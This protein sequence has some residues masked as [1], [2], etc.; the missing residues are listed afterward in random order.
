MSGV[1]LGVTFFGHKDPTGRAAIVAES[2]QSSATKL[3]EPPL[4]NKVLSFSLSYSC[5]PSTILAASPLC[6][7]LLSWL[8][9]ACNLR[10]L[11]W[12]RWVALP[13]H[14][15]N[16]CEC[17]IQT[18]W[19]LAPPSFLQKGTRPFY[20]TA[21]VVKDSISL[22]LSCLRILRLL[23]AAATPLLTRIDTMAQWGHIN[24][25]LRNISEC[26]GCA[27]PFLLLCTSSRYLKRLMTML[28]HCKASFC[29]IVLAIW[30]MKWSEISKWKNSEHLKAP[31]FVSGS[32]W[33][34]SSVHCSL[35]YKPRALRG[36]MI[37]LSFTGN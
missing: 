29:H 8:F 1:T 17:L 26:L 13:H 28:S 34:G 32:L 24:G 16:G 30:M 21:W 3:H 19:H 31:T 35:F 10:C 9:R 15:S 36:S 23:A 14:R 7:L 22:L 12:Q 2:L 33:S 20:R 4:L 37:N 6:L 27:S 25:A 11:S 5:C 18:W